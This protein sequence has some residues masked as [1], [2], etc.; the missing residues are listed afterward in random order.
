[1]DIE[2]LATEI[3]W[4]S[5]MDLAKL[6]DVLMAQFNA[7]AEKLAWNLQVSSTDQALRGDL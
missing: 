1:M 5:N 3:A 2:T 6:A 4:L 7:R